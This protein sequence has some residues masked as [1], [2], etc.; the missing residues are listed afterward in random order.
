MGPAPGVGPRVRLLRAL[1]A[2]QL[3]PAI[4]RVLEVADLRSGDDVVDVACGT[5][6]VTLP[7]AAAVGPTGRVLA[8]DLSPKMVD[9]LA[10]RARCC[11]L[12]NVE[13]AARGAEELEE[14][15]SFDVRA[16]L[17]RPDVRAVTGGRRGGDA[18]S[19]A[20]RRPDRRVGVG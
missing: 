18:P 2:R 14:V 4:D 7:A 10:E 12:D 15:E 8:T 16:L 3:Q 6:M 17:A 20:A 11:G 13:V 5:G 9:A 1:L 19:A